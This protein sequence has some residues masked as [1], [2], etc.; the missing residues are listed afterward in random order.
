MSLCVQVFTHC[1]KDM[2]ST[3]VIMNMPLLLDI[4]TLYVYRYSHIAPKIRLVL[5]WLMN[6]PLLSDVGMGTD[7]HT[8]F[9]RYV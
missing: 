3:E 2:F 4:H 7:F 1:S 5:R 8:L 6:M 9:Q